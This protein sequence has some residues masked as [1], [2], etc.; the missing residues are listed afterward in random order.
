MS[1]SSTARSEPFKSAIP[2]TEGEAHAGNPVRRH[3]SALTALSSES[4]E[5]PNC[6]LMTTAKPS[7]RSPTRKNRLKWL[8]FLASRQRLLV[9]ALSQVEFCQVRMSLHESPDPRFSSPFSLA[10][11]AFVILASL[12]AYRTE[13]T[14]ARCQGESGS[15]S[16]RPF[17]SAAR[18]PHPVRPWGRSGCL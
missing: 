9:T 13:N 16:A 14:L 15:K 4:R 1:R 11:D 2:L 5:N 12:E 3:V 8:G 7:C 6:V 17:P 10:A 18:A